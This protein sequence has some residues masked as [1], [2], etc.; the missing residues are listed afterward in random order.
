[1][2]MVCDFGWRSD[3]FFKNYFIPSIFYKKPKK[4]ATMKEFLNKKIKV[5]KTFKKGQVMTPRN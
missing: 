3:T 5:Q 4:Q 1:M 2:P